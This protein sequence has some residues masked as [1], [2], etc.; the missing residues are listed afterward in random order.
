MKRKRKR[1]DDT[2][3]VANDGQAGVGRRA[4]AEARRRRGKPT[5]FVDTEWVRKPLLRMDVPK[6]VMP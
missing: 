1:G 5:E 2:V 3:L 4:I 6:E